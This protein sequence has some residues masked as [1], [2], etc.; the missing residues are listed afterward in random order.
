MDRQTFELKQEIVFLISIDVGA[1]NETNFNDVR[2]GRV[3]VTFS[4]ISAADLH[5]FRR[6]RLFRD[7]GVLVAGTAGWRRVDWVERSATALRLLRTTVS[8][9]TGCSVSVHSFMRLIM[10][11]F[12]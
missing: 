10:T 2:S 7:D 4:T 12:T 1:G 5:V 11:R 9:A 8:V 3:D 6:R